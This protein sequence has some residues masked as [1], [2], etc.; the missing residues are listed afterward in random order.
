MARTDMN[1]V[2]LTGTLVRDPEDIG[3]NGAGVRFSIAVNEQWRNKETQ[4]FDE[5]ANFFDLVTWGKAAEPVRRFLGKGSRVAVTGRLKQERWQGDEG[6]RS[7]V[8]VHT[9]SIVFLDKKGERG[10]GSDIPSDGF[11]S[12]GAGGGGADDDDIPF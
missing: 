6:T 5:Y 12:G 4:Q 7:K 2:S 10:G 3:S 11:Q 8:T 9:A 1:T